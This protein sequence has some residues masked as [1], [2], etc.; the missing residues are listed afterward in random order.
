MAIP[1]YGQV[2]P[3]EEEQFLELIMKLLAKDGELYRAM[4]RSFG[5]S[6]KRQRKGYARCA[7]PP[8]ELE[9]SYGTRKH[10]L[11]R[12]Q[13]WRKCVIQTWVSHKVLE[14]DPIRYTIDVTWSSSTAS[15]L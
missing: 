10:Q 12:Q 8:P 9:G 5:A 7:G 3:E 1:E 4:V 15:C 11:L 13:K 14:S 2:P 6:R